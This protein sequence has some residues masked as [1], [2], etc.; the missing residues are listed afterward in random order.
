[1]PDRPTLTFLFRSWPLSGVT[2]HTV[3]LCRGLKKRGWHCRIAF[4]RYEPNY[5]LPFPDDLEKVHWQVN[6]TWRQRLIRLA[7]KINSEP[8]GILFPEFAHKYAFAVP[9]VNPDW[10]IIQRL[11]SD[12]PR[13]YEQVKYLGQSVDHLIAVSHFIGWRTVKKFPFVDERL[14]TIHYAVPGRRTDN[15]RANRHEPGTPLKILYLGRLEQEQKRVLDI[16]DIVDELDRRGILTQWTLAGEGSARAQLTSRMSASIQ[17]GQVKLPGLVDH[18]RI[19]ALMREHHVFLLTS[20]YEGLPLALLE[21]QRAGLIPVVPDIRS[22]VGEVVRHRKNGFL[23]PV[24]N[25]TSFAD[26]LQSLAEG[27][28]EA[29]GDSL[30][31][32]S[33]SSFPA[34]LDAYEAVFMTNKPRVKSRPLPFNRIRFPRPLR[35]LL[36]KPGW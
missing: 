35:E 17:S 30:M 26:A 36:D 10:R 7:K 8:P 2:T 11:H 5:E 27:E 1:M 14:Q 23:C 25:I 32:P 16:P 22:G 34:M 28:A 33:E 24:G 20:D 31:N 19:D 21:A 15:Q 29:M 6:G 13:Y 9:M 4:L 18:G 12:D 3:D